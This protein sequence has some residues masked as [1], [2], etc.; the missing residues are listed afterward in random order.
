[1]GVAVIPELFAKRQ[2][3]HRSE[4]T[5][6]PLEMTEASRT[7]ALMVADDRREDAGTT[8]LVKALR[9]AALALEMPLA[10]T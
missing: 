10:R 7:I 6:R 9:D 2:A 1:A 4:V 8:L 5:V 3:V